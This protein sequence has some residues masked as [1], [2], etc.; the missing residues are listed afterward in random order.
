MEPE[1]GELPVGGIGE[2]EAGG[3]VVQ[4]AE[5]DPLAALAVAQR[6]PDGPVVAHAPGAADGALA[7]AQDELLGRD[8]LG[9]AG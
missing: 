9:R 6:D 4:Q 7:V 8:G 5:P 1:H 3:A 2:A